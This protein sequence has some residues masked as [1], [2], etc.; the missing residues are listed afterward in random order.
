[1]QLGIYGLG[2]MGANMARRLSRGG[3]EVVAHNRSTSPIDELVAEETHITG[4][5]TLK[6][7]VDALPAPRIVWLMLPSGKVTEDAISQILPLLKEGDLLIDGGNSFYQDTIAR[8][9]RVQKSGVHY[10]DVGTSG[11]I[12]GLQNGYSL[13][14]GGSDEAAALITPAIRVLAPAPDQGW[15]HVGPVGSGHYVK[16]VHNG[17]E[18]GMM[19]ALAEGLDLLRAK[20]EFDLDLAQITEMWRYGSVVQSWLLDLT[21]EA[22]AEQG[23]RLEHI[24]PVVADSGEGRWT[25]KEAIDLG[26][27]APVMTL[28]LQMRFASQDAEGYGNRLLS[29]M[30]NA[31]GGH[32]I[33]K[34]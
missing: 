24:A 20:K 14:F 25:A 2:R 31:F 6:E 29:L 18:Y 15:G 21:A 22:L 27:S 28:A 34:K 7:F 26:V 33:T 5:Y 30:R 9:A 1:M 10:M 3:I 17:I 4:A 12:W 13:M 16:M 32:A 19:Q 11:G 23:Q 8:A